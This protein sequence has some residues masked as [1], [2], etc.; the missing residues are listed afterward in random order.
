MPLR[1]RL[2]SGYLWRRATNVVEPFALGDEGQ[3]TALA[4]ADNGW[5]AAA[6]PYADVVRVSTPRGTTIWLSCYYPLT[7]AWAGP[8]LFVCTGEGDVLLFRHLQSAL[9]E[10]AA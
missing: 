1:R 6:H 4:A 2:T 7:V 9:M 5:S 10:S 3:C 8:S